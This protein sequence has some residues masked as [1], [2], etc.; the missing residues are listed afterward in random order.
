M[1]S[2]RVIIPTTLISIILLVPFSPISSVFLCVLFSL[3]LPTVK[4]KYLILFILAILSFDLAIIY[5][6]KNFHGDASDFE[7]YYQ[8]Y[9]NILHDQSVNIV[10]V[11]FKEKSHFEPL[12]YITN[13]II[14]L[15][16]GELS[17][18]NLSILFN[19]IS[20]YSIAISVFIFSSKYTIKNLL[21][22]VVLTLFISKIGS[23]TLFWRQSLSA[24]F[25]ILFLSCNG[26]K[27]YIFLLV[28]IGF[29]VSSIVVAPLCYLIL[30]KKKSNVLF[31]VLIMFAFVWPILGK[32]IL[33]LVTHILNPSENY[34]FTNNMDY[35]YFMDTLKTIVFSIPIVLLYRLETIKK[36]P[37]PIF[38]TLLLEILILIAF[39]TTP[40]FFRIIYPIS[41]AIIY[42]HTIILM[43]KLKNISFVLSLFFIILI[44]FFRLTSDELS[45]Q[46]PLYSLTPFYY[47][48]I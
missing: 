47:L 7:I 48:Y 1:F 27:K 30:K 43:L 8:F 38:Y 45:Y 33:L 42:L 40:H 16:L 26:F 23:M 6:A 46:F 5:S 20:I 14:S 10:D 18:I 15:L 17:E 19:F 35:P 41:V 4:N 34:F 13:F 39:A 11:F 22:L 21:F 29:H 9:Q 3:F 24:A 37:E 36:E 2:H 32:N 12:Y 25:I 28:A 31:I 44:N